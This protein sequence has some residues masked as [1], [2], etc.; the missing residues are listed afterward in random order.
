MDNRPYQIRQAILTALNACYPGGQD[1]AGLTRTSGCAKLA[2]APAE[3]LVQARFL[4]AGGYVADLRGPGREPW[5]KIAQAGVLQI[6]RETRL[7]E[8]VWGEEAL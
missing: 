5:W 1:L 8:A 7:A 4:E 2:A 6:Q 3:V